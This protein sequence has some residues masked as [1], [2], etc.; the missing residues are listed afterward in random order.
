VVDVA[1]LMNEMDLLHANH[2]SA[3]KGPVVLPYRGILSIKSCSIHNFSFGLIAGSS[4]I[5]SIELSSIQDAK[6]AALLTIN[7]KILKISGTTIDN[8]KSSS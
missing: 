1:F 2:G 7:P 6:K 5:I 3:D 4:S 8:Q